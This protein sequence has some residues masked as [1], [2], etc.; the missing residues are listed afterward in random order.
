[1]LNSDR[2]RGEGD[3]F[4]ARA[5]PCDCLRAPAFTLVELLTVLAV[6]GLLAGILIPTTTTARIG[7]KR[8][9]TKVQFS[10]WAAGMEQFRQEYGYYPPIDGCSGGRV[11]ADYFAGALTGR[12]FDGS[13]PASVAH[14]AGN[15]NAVRFYS[16]AE[17]DLNDNRSALADAFG[18][19][20]IAVL[21]DKNG[22][23]LIDGADGE[24]IGV[25]PANGGVP[26]SPPIADVDLNGGVRAGV[27][28]YS[29][30]IGR[31][32]SDVVV[33]ER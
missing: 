19:T 26:L 8:A 28:F 2:R 15:T 20:D 29:A 13:A 24:L 27:I 9:K 5:T 21:Y 33:V 32:P 25:S 12:T 14:L 16:I 7:A 22:D 30:G 18:N 10:Q 23:G 31:A 6:I 11:S 17:S 1:M 4:R 3:C